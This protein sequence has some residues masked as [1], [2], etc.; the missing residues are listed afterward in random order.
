MKTYITGRQLRLVGK[1]YEI[2]WQLKSMLEASVDPGQP[3]SCELQSWMKGPPFPSR[4]GHQTVASQRSRII[5]F[6]A[7]A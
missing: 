2:R 6:P 3:L 5:P 7:Q 1:A 4:N